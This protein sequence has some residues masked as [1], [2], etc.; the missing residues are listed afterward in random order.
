MAAPSPSRWIT[1]ARRRLSE[2]G[3]VQVELV[4]S[5]RYQ[6]E[7]PG[8]AADPLRGERILAFLAAQGLTSARHLH[9]P[10]AATY[11]Q[12][13]F[14]HTD[15][16]IDSLSR[17]GALLPIVGFDLPDP[18]PDRILE[19]QRRMVGG[20]ILAAHLALTRGL[21]INFGGGLHHA[22][23]DRGERFCLWNDVAIA[24]HDLREG[25][26]SAPVLV[27]D[28]DLH[29][30]DGTRALFADDPTVHV[31]SIH[32]RT[33]PGVSTAG[34]T[35]V[36]L[37]SGVEDGPYLA[38]I[39]A[40]LPPLLASVRPGLVL[41]LAGCDPAW[42]DEIGDWQITDAGMLA[43]DRFVVE[44]VRGGRK[45]HRLPLA[46]VLAGGYGQRAWTYSARFFAWLLSGKVLTPPSSED[47]T[48][49]R[50]RATAA[51]S[52][53][54]ELTGEEAP[55]KSGADDWGL[56]PEDLAAVGGVRAR[57]RFLGFY[58]RQGLE[59]AIERSGL[60]DRVRARGFSRLILDLEL[61]NPGGE[62]LRLKADGLNE[63][64][65]ELRARIDRNAVPEMAMLRVEWLLLQ[66][67]R[68]RFTAERPRLPGQHHPGLGLLQDVIALLVVACERLHLD[69]LVFVPAYYH[70]AAQG[71]RLLRF[72]SP[73][74][75]GL[76]QAIQAALAP[77]PLDE[78][79][80]AFEEGRV[81][82]AATGQVF[83]WQ[84]MAM[85][86]PVTDRL[87]QQLMA[88]DYERQAEA[89]AQRSFAVRPAKRPGGG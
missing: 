42:D 63:P 12:L 79:T 1:R 5:R 75:E 60:L 43:R 55:G 27:V 28:L 58:T 30:G 2:L 44:Q 16:Y 20:T 40:G 70:T 19:A 89:A 3:R 62:T 29:D 47:M 78:A 88:P 6:I 50:Y 9:T 24:I 53:S 83:R 45:G 85:V 51:L 76:F 35:L 80:A 61:D 21:A 41:Y 18:L 71:K 77:F 14:V 87:Q 22:Y 57:S 82:D 23:A 13:R 25:G 48:L 73:E 32:N 17:P 33:T 54:H 11:R 66:N 65:I 49:A 34:A 36:E 46:I 84:P 86:L 15:D 74:H 7:L 81:V 10:E 31:L 26:F 72:L 59:L 38:A 56:S 8:A 4:Y 68:A 52:S 67:P 64:L 69:G 39:E 37:G